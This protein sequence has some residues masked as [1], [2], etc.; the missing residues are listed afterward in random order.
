MIPTNH[1]RERF[2]HTLSG[3]CCFFQCGTASLQSAGQLLSSLQHYAVHGRPVISHCF[4]PHL[5]SS[6]G[7]A[8]RF[9]LDTQD[10]FIR[11]SDVLDCRQNACTTVEKGM[12]YLSPKLVCQRAHTQTRKGHRNSRTP[13]RYA[14][15]RPCSN[16][17]RYSFCDVKAESTWKCSNGTSRRLPL[18]SF[19]PAPCGRKSSDFNRVVP[20]YGKCLSLTE[21]AIRTIALPMQGTERQ[22]VSVLCITS[23]SHQNSITKE[24]S[25]EQSHSHT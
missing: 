2:P 21:L 7:P 3:K 16:S 11:L 25:H 13:F 5:S 23:L 19:L 9:P 4:P 10:G 22:N 6:L 18:T 15:C 17:R 12:A 1:T 14:G 8:I 20:W 24:S